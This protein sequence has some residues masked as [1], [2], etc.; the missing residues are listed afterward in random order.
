MEFKLLGSIL[1]RKYC[2]CS[3]LSENLQIAFLIPKSAKQW[4]SEKFFHV[5]VNS[6]RF[7]SV[8]RFF[9]YMCFHNKI[10]GISYSAELSAVVYNCFKLDP[11]EDLYLY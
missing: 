5:R 7:Q 8:L 9:E 4:L 2:S 3:F 6:M 1:Y 11:R 10:I